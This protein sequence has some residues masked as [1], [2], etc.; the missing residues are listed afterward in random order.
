MRSTFNSDKG[1]DLVD[2]Y[3]FEISENGCDSRCSVEQKRL[4]GLG[5]DQQ[6]AARAEP[7]VSGTEK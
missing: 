3:E 7:R 6:H 5:C 2:D 4:N 1:V